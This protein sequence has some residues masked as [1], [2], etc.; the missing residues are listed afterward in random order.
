[1]DRSDIVQ[2]VAK[3]YTQ[4][5]IGQYIEAQMAR[6][7]FCNIASATRSEWQSAGQLGFKPELVITMFAPDYQGEELAVINGVSYG[8]YRTYRR[9][10]EL[11][12]LY[13]EK[14]VGEYED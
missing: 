8:V 9:D 6:P 10:D 3:T 11:L 5:S 12:E 4:D 14:K 7:V 1:M 2:F 13:L